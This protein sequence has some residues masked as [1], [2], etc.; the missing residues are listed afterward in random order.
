MARTESERRKRLREGFME[1][2]GQNKTIE[3]IAEHFQVS[4]WTVYHALDDI[5]KENGVTREDLLYVVQEPH[6]V[7]KGGKK[8]KTE[9]IQP[10]ELREHF[11][12]LENVIKGIRTEIRKVIQEE[13]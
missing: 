2:R 10:E 3:E 8:G 13:R 4:T 9:N 12:E 5:A 6:N 7:A 11:Y 1:M